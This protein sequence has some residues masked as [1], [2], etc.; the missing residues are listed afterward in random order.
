MDLETI[1]KEADAKKPLGQRISEYAATGIITTGLFT[2]MAAGLLL[3]ND[4]TK[5]SEYALLGSFA[6]IP[7]FFVAAG[8][9]GIYRCDD[10]FDWLGD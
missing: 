3:G 9:E 6:C 10:P 7:A 1:A 2:S 8:I 5:L 4:Y